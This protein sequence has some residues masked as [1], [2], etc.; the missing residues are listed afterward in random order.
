M[1]FLSVIITVYNKAGHIKN[2]IESV[3]NQSF[4]EFELIIIN[5]GST[6]TSEV[7]IKSF[8]DPRIRL[9]TTKNNGA[10]FARN[11]GIKEAASAYIAL[12][13][14]DDTWDSEYLQHIHDAILN[15]PTY[16][17]FTTAIAQNYGTHFAPVTYSFKQNELYGI[18]N[19]FEASKKYTLITS[20]S[21][22]FHKSVLTTTGLF[23]TSIISGQ[24][25]DMWIRF[26]LNYKIVFINRLLVF[27][28]YFTSS[29]SNTTFDLRKKPKFDKY[30]VEEKDNRQLK[31]F[32]DKN[33]YAMAILS[34]LQNDHKH[35]QYYKAHLDLKNLNIRQNLL[36][37]SPIW[38]LHLLLK[39]KNL[40]GEKIYYPK[41]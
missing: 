8:K 20:S 40:K 29:L 39:I 28:N 6:D 18:Y 11:L 36:L 16:K 26:G 1:S 33:R 19:F 25:T 34:K 15:F 4:K 7:L 10:S 22:V 9:L 5:D 35:Y 2:T 30:L 23:D 38:L 24:D 14:G 3:L 21:V 41:S 13:D 37:K 31:F 32:L 12:L 27:Y 17:I